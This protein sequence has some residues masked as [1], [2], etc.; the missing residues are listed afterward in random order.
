MVHEILG[1]QVINLEKCFVLLEE[2]AVHASVCV[3]VNKFY[4]VHLSGVWHEFW[5]QNV[6]VVLK[7]AFQQAN[8]NRN[9]FVKMGYYDWILSYL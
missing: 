7:W 9:T 4:T 6:F 1:N 8:C 5:S 3:C 2:E